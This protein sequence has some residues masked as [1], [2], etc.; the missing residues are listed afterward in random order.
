M[1]DLIPLQPGHTIQQPGHTIQQPGH[2]IQ[3]PGHTIQQP[4]H[5]IQQPGRTIQQPGHTIQ[6]SR[7]IMEGTT[8]TCEHSSQK[9]ATTV[10]TNSS[11]S[12]PVWAHDVHT[13]SSQH[14]EPSAEYARTNTINSKSMA[15]IVQPKNRQTDKQYNQ[16]T[17]INR[18]TI[19][20]HTKVTV[21]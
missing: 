3:Q 6:Q 8:V 9:S 2:T 18:Y 20:P 16:Q 19:I 7:R 15:S 13:H 10:H 17:G 4:G 1:R 5:T 12:K 11:K 14:A 21:Y